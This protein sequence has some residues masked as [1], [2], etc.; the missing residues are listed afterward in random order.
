MDLSND[1]HVEVALTAVMYENQRGF[2]IFGKAW[3]SA[4]GL[5][6]TDPTPFT[7]P[8]E[9]PDGD[10]TLGRS[11]AK[12]NS[13]N[14]EREGSSSSAGAEADPGPS[15][16][17][18][19]SA[20]NGRGGSGGT[21]DTERSASSTHPGSKGT[22]TRANG[23]IKRRSIKTGYSLK[24]YETPSPAW[25]WLTPWM[26]NM[27]LDTDHQGWRYNLWF[28]TRGWASHPGRLNWWGW[29]RRREWVRLRALL[30]P[31]EGDDGNEQEKQAPVPKTL[32]EVLG[33]QRPVAN[34]MRFL[35]VYALDREKLAVWEGWMKKGSAGARHRLADLFE[36]RE[37]VSGGDGSTKSSPPAAAAPSK[38]AMEDADASSRS[39]PARSSTRPPARR[40]SRASWRTASSRTRRAWS[41]RTSS[42]TA[43]SRV[44]HGVGRDARRA[45][46]YWHA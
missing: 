39:C 14:H 36:D 34:M 28:H 31:E 13:R 21:G 20:S 43:R 35:A 19:A 32:D 11:G 33:V 8:L 7:L 23:R 16:G 42:S 4:N 37:K 22:A 41:A 12:G 18:E 45:R 24:T 5:L 46:R 40:S 44:R 15:N 29:V 3:Y 2:S 38:P 1:G 26:V 30:P 27:R 9:S 6:P 25:A 10:F 17:R